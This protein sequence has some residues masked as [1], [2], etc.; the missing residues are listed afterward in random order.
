MGEKNSSEN[1]F[2]IISPPWEKTCTENIFSFLGK[3]PVGVGWE[4]KYILQP[5]E[6][7]A[8]NIHPCN[9]I[10]HSLFYLSFIT[11][12][13]ISDHMFFMPVFASLGPPTD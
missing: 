7:L 2:F 1:F 9:K 10:I 11:I 8:Q 6:N 12:P 4:M 3:K 5:G 13:M